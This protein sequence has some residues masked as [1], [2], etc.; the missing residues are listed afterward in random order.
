[1]LIETYFAFL[2]ICVCVFKKKSILLF[3]SVTQEKQEL[4]VQIGEYG[5]ILNHVMDISHQVYGL[6]VGLNGIGL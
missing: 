1:M 5:R 2:F 4:F 3:T 6:S